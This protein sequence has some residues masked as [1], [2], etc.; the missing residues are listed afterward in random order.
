MLLQPP[1]PPKAGVGEDRCDRSGSGWLSAAAAAAAAAAAGVGG[2]D[3]HLLCASR[4][5]VRSKT[6]KQDTS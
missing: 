5:T 2:G 4:L 6:Q 3:L 1:P